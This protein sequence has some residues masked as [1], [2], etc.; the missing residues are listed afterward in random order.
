MGGLG[1][2]NPF[3]QIGGNQTGNGVGTMPGLG[4][5]SQ[6]PLMGLG[7]FGGFGQNQTNPN[8][9]NNAQNLNQGQFPGMFGGFNPFMSSFMNPQN[10]QSQTPNT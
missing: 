7:G 1:A 8:I 10:N 4:G 9:E 3:A 5:L 6:N 2:M